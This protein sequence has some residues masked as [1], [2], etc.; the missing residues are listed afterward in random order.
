MG[1]TGTLP[2]QHPLERGAPETFVAQ[3]VSLAGNGQGGTHL[4]RWAGARWRA[5]AVK[6]TVSCGAWGAM[7]APSRYFTPS[8]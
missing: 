5:G 6:V 8:L 7:A 4:E 3:R 2:A 1:H